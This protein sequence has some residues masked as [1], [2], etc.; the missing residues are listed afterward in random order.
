[1]TVNDQQTA[2]AV[3][4]LL[5]DPGVAKDPGP[6]FQTL[7]STYPVAK[8][9]EYGGFWLLSRYSDVH[10]A[11]LDTDA[12]S[13]AGGVTIP[14]APSPPSLCLEQDE[15]EHRIY[16]RPMQ[17]WFSAGRMSQLEDQV[18]AIVTRLVDQVADDARGDLGTALAEP[19]PPIVIGLLLGLPESEW[20]WFR[21]RNSAYLRLGAEGDADGAYAAVVE[22]M[23][24]LTGQLEERRRSPRADML[25]DIV[26][27]A[28]D[29]EQISPEQALSIAFLLLAAGH[30]TTVGAIGGMIY[31]VA[32]NRD[33]RDRLLAD[34]S[35]VRDAVEEAL[36]LEPSL[37]GLGRTLRKDT[38]VAGV[39]MP[40]GER[41]MLLYGSANRDGEVFDK[42]EEFRVDRPN[43]RHLAFGAGIH[44]CVGAPLARLEMRIVLEEILR[45]LPGI[46]LEDENAVKVSYAFSRAYRALPAVW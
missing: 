28:V 4:F 45:R 7:R 33:V 32:A 39:P 31:H 34:P 38:T 26:Q 12:F 21:E 36:R 19:L 46:R 23:G 6:Y 29:G 5:P 18:R 16:R 2:P 43:N 41:V 30:E 14:L 35:L 24:Y 9:P 8:T 25:T 40:E 37:M 42:P 15:P 20:P 27:L 11:A 13:S 3:D 44:R 10:A 17:S 22:L 1:M